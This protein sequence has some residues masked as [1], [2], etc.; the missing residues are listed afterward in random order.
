MRLRFDYSLFCI[1]EG[2]PWT[3]EP[4]RLQSMGFSRQ[5]YWS[6]VPLSSPSNILL[7]YIT[8]VVI[9]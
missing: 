7:L 5:E 8:D 1:G 3:E 4:G 2:I 9:C 6:R